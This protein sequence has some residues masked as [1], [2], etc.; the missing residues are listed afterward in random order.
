LILKEA[1][2]NTA[3]HARCTL[4]NLTIALADHRLEIGIE[5]NG[6]GFSAGNSSERNEYDPP[7]HGLNNMKL[8]AAQLGG[9]MSIDSAPGRGTKLRVTVPLR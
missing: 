1:V 8:R 7:G 6:R 4:V 2:N 9:Q 5:D 3:R